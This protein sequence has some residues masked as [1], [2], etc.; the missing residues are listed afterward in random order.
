MRQPPRP[1]SAG[2]QT[3]VLARVGQLEQTQ[4]CSQPPAGGRPLAT[5]SHRPGR[6]PTLPVPPPAHAVYYRQPIV[7]GKSHHKLSHGG[8]GSS[9]KRHPGRLKPASSSSRPSVNALVAEV[10]GLLGRLEDPLPPPPLAAALLL[11][12]ATNSTSSTSG[13]ESS[14]SSSGS[15]SESEDEGPRPARAAAASASSWTAADFERQRQELLARV[16][17]GS[18]AAPS[19]TPAPAAAATTQQQAAASGSKSSAV[20]RSQRVAQPAAAPVTVEVCTGKACTKRGAAAVLAAAQ[21]A[22]AAPA[23]GAARLHVAACSKCMGKC[24]QA[25]AVRVSAGGTTVLHTGVSPSSV[26]TVLQG[27]PAHADLFEFL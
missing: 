9:S 4:V 22:A 6:P 10:E 14:S 17:S 5:R 20:P 13:Y 23:A 21:A 18:L 26:R 11:G 8:G 7:C 15:S 19:A 2:P 24:K 16:A 27:A 12:P 3:L 1:P 25:P